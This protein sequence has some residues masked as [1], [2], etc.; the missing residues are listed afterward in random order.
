MFGGVGV[1]DVL[2]GDLA[3]LEIELLDE[4]ES[5]M[6]RLTRRVLMQPG[7]VVLLD[8]YQTLHGRETFEGPRRHGVLWLTS[9]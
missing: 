7:D 8:S 1:T 4:I 3:P 9:R 2:D 6:T 5:V